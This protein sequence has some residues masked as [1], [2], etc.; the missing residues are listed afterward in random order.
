MQIQSDSQLARP[1]APL[2]ARER[3]AALD[4]VR[5]F[6]LIGILIMNVEFF[7]R[8]GAEN[9]SGFQAGLSGIDLWVAWFVAYFVIG[10]FWTMFSLLFGMGFA[11]MLTRTEQAGRDFLHPYLRRIGAL[12][13]F[14]ALHHILLWSG[15][16][17]FSYAVAASAL[18]IVLYGRARYI[19]PGLLVTGAVA[20]VVQQE[21]AM[22]VPFGLLIFSMAALFL[23]HERSVRI[24]ARTLPVLA[25]I[26]L[27]IGAIEAL[28][29]AAAW[30][31]PSFPR[32]ARL[33]PLPFACLSMTLGVL[34][35]R[36]HQPVA[37]RPWRLGVGLYCFLTLTMTTVGAIQYYFPAPQALVAPAAASALAQRATPSL[38]A[39]GTA[40]AN[41]GTDD[42]DKAK[43]LK[44]H[45]DEVANETRVLSHG[46]Y[47]DAVTM[48]A[49]NF[50]DNA[51][52][53]IGFACML[54]GIFLLGFWFVRSGIMADTGAH[55][56]L[57]RKLALYGLP[58]GIGL[59]LLGSSIATVHIPGSERDGWMLAK[60]LLMLGNLP[61]CLGYV[62]VMIL[63]LNSDSVFNKVSVLAPF[64]RMALSNYLL[65]SVIASSFF[66]GYGF[67]HWGMARAW[68]MVY[69]LAVLLLQIPLSHWWLARYRYGPA[70][71]LWRAITYWQVPAMRIE[72]R[73]AMPA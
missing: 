17:L 22:V 52:R 26:T 33:F 18:L 10:K 8:A 55:L 65:Q 34:I 71:W 72:T 59:G 54:I 19:V 4:V 9:G 14:G 44:E 32:E 73:G 28:L 6:A 39:A 47:A 11:V 58:F 64:G 56:P 68:Q 61:A 1:L 48:R 2:P 43:K 70:E 23:R 27:A 50:A 40:K 7:N 3:I 41:S 24:G 5:G 37:A 25:V 49:K 31:L 12:A 42:A 51:P 62:S 69:V 13:V 29:G 20:A 60:G 57:F 15:D 21:W 30:V 36:Y 16:I 35:A 67:G 53:R 46:S 63:M 38:A 66:F 45:A